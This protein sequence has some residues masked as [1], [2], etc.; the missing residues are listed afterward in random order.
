MEP[1]DSALSTEYFI[2]SATTSSMSGTQMDSMNTTH[3]DVLVIGAGP[4]GLMSAL[5][6]ARAGVNVKII[7]QKCVSLSNQCAEGT[8]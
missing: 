4:A 1:S 8:C 5:S 6:L 2:A 7:D 3:V